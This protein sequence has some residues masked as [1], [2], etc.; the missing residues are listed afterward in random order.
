MNKAKTD[1]TI[2]NRECGVFCRYLIGQT[3]NDYV[4]K[5]YRDAHRGRP[6]VSGDCF[7]PWDGFLVSIA[8]I[9]PWSTRIVDVYSRVFRGSSL[10]RKKL[11]LLLAI[12][13]SCEPSHRYLDSVDSNKIPLLALRLA[14][15]CLT[16][17]MMLVIVI[18]AILP[19]QLVVWAAAKFQ[20]LSLT[21]HG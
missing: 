11:V 9:G 19:L 21:H 20:G 17:V 14:S 4:R 2:L 1:L 10:I 15:G 12:L 3:P 18:V 5:K 13:E 6:F 16:F 7:G 8:T